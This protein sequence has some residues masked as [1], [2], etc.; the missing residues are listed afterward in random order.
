[1]AG[2]LPARDGV[3]ALAAMA[4]ILLISPD[5]LLALPGVGQHLPKLLEVVALAAVCWT[6]WHGRHSLRLPFA[7][8]L[9]LAFVGHALLSGAWAPFPQSWQAQIVKL[10]HAAL[11]APILCLALRRVGDVRTAVVV[12]KSV[13]MLCCLVAL[14]QRFLPGLQVDPLADDQAPGTGAGM[15]LVYAEEL[16][17]GAAVRVSGTLGHSNALSLFLAGSLCLQPWLW[18]RYQSPRARLAIVLLTLVEALAMVFTYGRLGLI[19]FAVAG[20]WLLARGGFR[21]PLRLLG[22]AA[23]ALVAVAPLLPAAW[24]ERVFDPGHLQRSE[25]IQGRW[26]LQIHGA[27]LGHELGF[28]GSGYG[29]FGQLVFRQMHGSAKEAIEYQ[30]GHTD[31]GYDLDDLGAH[32]AYLE[33]WVEQG[34]LGL[35]LWCGAGVAMLAGLVRLSR[36]APG[37]DRLLCV[38]LEATVI[39]FAVAAIFIHTQEMKVLWIALGLVCAWLRAGTAASLRTAALA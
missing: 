15:A 39:A 27:E 13:S 28:V 9:G 24:V 18:A 5:S 25:S 38:C 22:V 19:A 32:N 4:A 7:L 17:S 21:H 31:L 23:G 26:E 8:G 10:L 6:C 3:L 29:Q 36:A 12:F 1:M 2:A 30:I 14:A 35:L 34:W 20:A 37:H 11:L 16:S 33:V